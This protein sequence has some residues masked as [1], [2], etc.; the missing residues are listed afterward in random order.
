MPSSSAFFT[1]TIEGLSSEIRVTKFRG[2]EG[3]SELFSFEVDFVSEDAAIDF[4]SVVGKPGMLEM[5]T[6]DEPRCVHGIVSRIEETGVGQKYTSY[7]ATLVPAFWTL[8][9]TNDCC[10][11]QEK[12]IPQVIEDVLSSRGMSSGTDYKLDLAGSYSAREYVVQYRESDL[13]FVSRLMEEVGIFYFFEHTD[14]GH[15]L[16]LGDD[17]GKHPDIGGPVVLDF[18]GEDTGM[19]SDKEEVTSLRLTRTVRTGVVTMRSFNFQKNKLK[20]ETESKAKTETAIEDYDFDGRYVDEGAGKDLAKIRQESYAARRLIL[21]GNSNC[22]HLTGGHKFGVEDHPRDEFNGDW[23]LLRV[24]HFGEQ[25]QA[26]GAESMGG[27]GEQAYVNR[28]EAIPSDVPF[29]PLQLTERAL[30]DGPQ[31]AV[32]TGPSGEE[33]HCDAHGRVK[34]FFHW[35]RYGKQD[36]KSSCWVRVSQSHRISDL[37][38]PRVGEEVIVE[39]L[40]GDPDQP[41]VTGRVYNGGNQSPYALPG[42]KTKSTLKTLSSPGGNGFNELRFEDAS[43]SEEVFLHAQKDWNIVVGNDRTHTVGNDESE[44]VGHDATLEVKND[45]TRT[46]GANESVSIGGNQTVSIDGSRTE[47]VKGS[48]SVS[49]DGSRKLKVGATDTEEVAAKRTVS[50]GADDTLTVGGNHEASVE[51]NQKFTVSGNQN[52]T[53]SGNSGADVSGNYDVKVGGKGTLDIAAD[54]KLKAGAKLTIEG[55]DEVTIKCGGSKIVLK[56]SGI[57]IKGSKID[58]KADGNIKLKGSQIAAN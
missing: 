10:I 56:P 7:S 22:R 9:L 2:Q 6:N 18:R 21:S 32:V 1:L 49:I 28:F 31:T 44:T 33:I 58:V 41:I 36:D 39:F 45:R 47:A 57:E 40:E 3:L 53:V 50:V 42:D 55:G 5:T 46:V 26:A 14:S 16:V 34:V 23:V 17:P 20:L 52:M 48:D 27:G 43:G 4:E 35:D 54:L 11:W 25:P 51:G 38:I 8:G 29:R 13:A 37:A 30:V 12:T 15:T 19:Q 24:N